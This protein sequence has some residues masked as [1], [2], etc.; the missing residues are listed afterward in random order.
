M[1]GFSVCLGTHNGERYLKE[2]VESILLQLGAEDELLISDDE[3]SDGTLSLL[4]K[5]QDTRIRLFT[6]AAHGS[7]LRNFEFAISKAD[8]DVIVLSDQD[9][10]WLSGRLDAFR[11]EFSRSGNNV[12]LVSLD[13]TLVD[14]DLNILH[15]SQ[16]DLLNAGPGIL[17]NIITNTYVGCHLAF[18]R[19]LVQYLLP[20]PR[21]ISTH[22]LWIGLIAEFIGR[23]VFVKKSYLLFRRHA[24]NFTRKKYPLG[25]RLR[26]RFWALFYVATH[27]PSIFIKLR[28]SFLKR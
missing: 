10:I 15:E 8:R 12:V 25:C 18:R 28:T 20:F 17:K 24:S 7:P 22:D 5:Y 2:Q 6:G 3:S 11:Y 9:D 27:F 21:H 4:S 14:Q 16:F 19:S 13:S 26:W 23:T 1:S